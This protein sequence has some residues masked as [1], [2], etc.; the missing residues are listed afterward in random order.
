M[1]RMG[2]MWGILILAAL[3][4]LP[5]AARAEMYAEIYGGAIMGA[6]TPFSMPFT[7]A[8]ERT[9]GKST[10]SFTSTGSAHFPGNFDGPNVIGGLKLGTWFVPTGFLGYN[11]PDWMKYLGFYLDF[12]YHRQDYREQVGTLTEHYNEVK[13]PGGSTKS[14][15]IAG[16]VTFKSNGIAPTLAFMFAGRYGFFPD[17]EVPFGRLQPYVAVGPGL[18][19]ASQSRNIGF[20]GTQSGSQQ[21]YP[22]GSDLGTSN[23][24]AIALVVDAGIQYMALK[25]VSIDLFFRFQHANPSFSKPHWQDAGA[26]GPVEGM[27]DIKGTFILDRASS[28]FDPTWNLFSGQIGVSYHF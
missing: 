15:N 21:A 8:G 19:F 25:N 6:S 28:S 24:V 18:I 14:A 26:Q 10:F 11:Y 22:T 3:L 17:S 7:G 2:K 4:A 16:P 1:K 12:S 9:Q 23:N 27:G 5:A 13:N 20:L